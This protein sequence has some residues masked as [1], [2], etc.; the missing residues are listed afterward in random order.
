MQAVEI[1]LEEREKN[2]QTFGT[3]PIGKFFMFTEKGDVYIKRDS[4]TSFRL[5]G[6]VIDKIHHAARVH[7]PTDIKI[8]VK[9]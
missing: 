6:M 9:I 1:R 4:D 8:K 3:L 5:P 2:K 7:L